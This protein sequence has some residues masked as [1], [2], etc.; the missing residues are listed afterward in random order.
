MFQ[1]Q[2]FQIISVEP[3]LYSLPKVSFFR[4]CKDIVRDRTVRGSLV[5]VDN[6]LTILRRSTYL[7]IHGQ[8]KNANWKCNRYL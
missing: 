5:R 8:T 6:F 1:K 2:I 4:F 7:R 3:E